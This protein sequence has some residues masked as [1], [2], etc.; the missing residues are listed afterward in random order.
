MLE[1]FFPLGGLFRLSGLQD[2]QLF[3]QHSGI[4]VATY[5]RE[6][7]R[8]SIF[9]TYLGATLEVGNVWQDS[10]DISFDNSITAGSLFLGLATPIG[11]IYFGYGR[12]DTQEDS[13]YLYIG[14]RLAF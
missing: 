12:T 11:P 10:S 14:P 8:S 2:N 7:Q 5:M 13:V 9:Q 3:G 4:A 1:S 6:L